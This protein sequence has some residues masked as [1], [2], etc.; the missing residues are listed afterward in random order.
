M[1]YIA[2][3][4]V[5]KAKEIDL[6]SYLEA[7]EPD[8]LVKVSKGIYCTK[9]HDSLKISN[10]KW[11]WWSRGFGGYNALDYLTKVKG[12]GFLDAV[13]LII[14][15]D[16]SVPARKEKIVEQVE[17]NLLLPKFSK[18]NSKVVNYLVNQRCIGAD[19]VNYCIDKGIIKE[20]LPYHNVVF[21]G[22]DE[23][24]KPR[25]AAFRA[26]NDSRVL[27]D[28]YG[29]NKE[30]S[31]RICDVYDDKIHLFESAI[32]LLSY[33][34]I[35]HDRGFDFTKFSLISLAGVYQPKDEIEDSKVPITLSKHLE[36]HPNTKTI[37]VHFDNDRA[38]RRATK[39]LQIILPKDIDV[40]NSPSVYGKDVNDYLCHVRRNCRCENEQVERN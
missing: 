15:T 27:G 10:G 1:P 9:E 11:M 21:I 40:V 36:K 35:L 7:N 39:A 37:C 18:S 20:S 17:K 4:I 25:Y 28:C 13:N 38:G 8:N 32:D 33:A 14:G 23:L 22:V 12:Y 5:A 2:P 34:T 6:L 26:T 24:N 16:V 29:S 19:V 31:F 30:F 3:E